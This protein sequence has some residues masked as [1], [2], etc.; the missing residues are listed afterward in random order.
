MNDNFKSNFEIQSQN[1]E[2]K[3]PTEQT[4]KN[5][6]S[7]LEAMKK[8]NVSKEKMEHIINYVLKLAEIES[9][10]TDQKEDIKKEVRFFIESS[11][12][13]RLYKHLGEYNISKFDIDS[14]K[15]LD[16]E[17]SKNYAKAI[18]GSIT[19]I[20]LL[21]WLNTFSTI[22]HES[23]SKSWLANWDKWLANK[24]DLQSY[25]FG[26]KDGKNFTEWLIQKVG[27][28]TEAELKKMQE[29]PFRPTNSESWGEL[30]ILLATTFWNGV[31][32]ILKFVANIPAW[33]ILIPRY[34]SYRLWDSD[35][36]KTR[37]EAEIKI[38]ELVEQN[39]SLAVLELLWDKWTEMIK[40]LW[41]IMTS[42]KQWDI[43]N[44][45]LAIAGLIA[46]GASVAKLGLN[47]SR[48]TAVN[49]ARLAW[50]EARIAWR[51]TSQATRANLKSLV[52]KADK[53][54]EIWG[55][56][57]NIIWWA[58]MLHLAWWM[59]VKNEKIISLGAHQNNTDEPLNWGQK[60]NKV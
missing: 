13:N 26:G 44:I 28:I 56:I 21:G 58:G 54:G 50:R 15:G 34:T 11:L 51:T 40:K 5:L 33:V 19:Q 30:W 38:K 36:P 57:D 16:T 3:K 46:W 12:W 53:V 52:A 35:D 17:E 23:N 1:I 59:L 31:E 7:M 43:A 24:V 60:I 41:D 18:G 22:H 37:T 32:D 25:I 39:P 8:W 2:S 48:K 6:G 27:N 9:K 14:Q 49:S 45:V 29:M 47:L 20:M 55:K 42:W 10:Y 4:E